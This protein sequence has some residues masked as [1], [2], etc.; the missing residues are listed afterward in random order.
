MEKKLIL[1]GKK[2]SSQNKKIKKINN[3]SEIEFK[4]CSQWGEDGIIDW[5]TYKF[6]NIPKSFLEIGTD[7]YF[8][9]NTRFLLINKNWDG[10]LIEANKEFVKKIRSQKIFWK[11]DLK[12]QNS[13]INKDN[14]NKIVKKMGVPKQLGLLS[15]DIDGIDYWVLKAMNALNPSIIICEFNSLYGKNKPITVHKKILLGQKNISA[16]SIMEHQLKYL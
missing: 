7:D 12:I 13:F 5:I 11:H 9:S 10:Y 3:L 4:V 6:P 16:I 8:E 1:E 2:I 14:I 15:L